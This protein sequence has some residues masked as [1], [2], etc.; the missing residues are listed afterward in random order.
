MKLDEI[1]ARDIFITTRHLVE[2]ESCMAF[3]MWKAI[4]M[5]K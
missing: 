3:L 5:V 2:E 1:L 4:C